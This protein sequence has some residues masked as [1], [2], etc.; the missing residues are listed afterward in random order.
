[1]IFLA[2][3]QLTLYW[4]IPF[5]GILLSLAFFPF[6]LKDLWHRHYGKIILGW[7]SLFI[8]PALFMN[9]YGTF[10]SMTHILLTEYVPFILLIG[11]LFVVTSGIRI[12]A[13][14][15]G[16]PLNN[17]SVL[18]CG[19]FLASWIG[20]TGASVLLIRPLMRANAWRRRQAHVFIFFIFLVGNVGG[21]LTPL[22]DPPLFIGFLQGVPF[23]WPLKYLLAPTIVAAIAILFVFW[24]VDSFFFKKENLSHLLLSLHA[25]ALK[26]NGKIN[27]VFLGL[28]I[29][30]ILGTG[31]IKTDITY[32]IF[33]TSISLENGMRDILLLFISFLSLKLTRKRVREDNH[34]SWPPL[35][36]V[37]KVFLGIF[38][39]VLPVLE[40]LKLGDQGSFGSMLAAINPQQGPNNTMY[41]WLSGFFSSFLDNAPTYLVFFFMA[42]GDS[43]LLTTTLSKTL[44]AISLGSVYLG[45]LTYIG[46]APNFMV[47]SIVEHRGI[48]M[49][50]FFS[51]LGISC[52][53]LLPI[54]FV[55]TL[56]YL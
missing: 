45:A 25:R 33:N 20:T 1:M 4:A 15:T 56:I 36:E 32:N 30:T 31:Y 23:L 5:V 28:I 6:L 8:I 40:I 48:K 52:L 11:T 55:L 27:L 44:M 13:N 7:T 53:V 14:W 3:E 54:F 34:F 37:A 12:Q 42:G 43:G 35:L 46:N 24:G 29:L 21:A 41:F 16:S 19:T 2:R 51:Y 50:T 49:P 18:L 38:I 17:V 9:T 47:K 39:T 22:G 10:Q 26:I